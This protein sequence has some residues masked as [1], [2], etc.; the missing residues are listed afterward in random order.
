MDADLFQT[1]LFIVVFIYACCAIF[2]VI[3]TGISNSTKSTIKFCIVVLMSLIS[4]FIVPTLVIY[5]I[6]KILFY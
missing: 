2:Y 3:K 4:I 1:S 6:L 5:I